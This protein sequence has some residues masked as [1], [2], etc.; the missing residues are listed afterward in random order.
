M[1]KDKDSQLARITSVIHEILLP[2]QALFI[3]AENLREETYQENIDIEFVRASSR[4]IIDEVRKLEMV[5]TTFRRALQASSEV[6]NPRLNYST[7]SILPLISQAASLFEKE[8]AAKGIIV[9]KPT[10]QL[11][12]VPELLMVTEDM[13]SVFINL[14]SNAVKYSYSGSAASERYIRTECLRAFM[15]DY[16]YLVIKVSNFGVGILREE[17]ENELIFQPGYRGKLSLDR[18]RTGSGTGLYVVREIVER[19]HNGKVEVESVKKNGG[20]L[21]T[22]TIMLPLQ[23]GQS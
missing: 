17:I 13:A 10:C 9:E 21:T 5:L 4:G 15:D 16:A 14:Y 6:E 19:E 12:P 11:H 18:N 22:V 20:Y 1:A 7:A 23:R 8:A 3:T 2:L